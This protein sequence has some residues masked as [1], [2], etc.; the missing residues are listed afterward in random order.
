MLAEFREL[1]RYRDLLMVLVARDIKVRYKRSALGFFWSLINP[2]MQTLVLTIVFKHVLKI[3]QP[4]YS[5]WVLAAI[6]PWTF[7]QNSVLDAAQSILLHYTLVKKV[8]FPREIIPL[9]SVISNLIHLGLSFLVFL[10]YALVIGIHFGPMLLWLPLLVFFHFL[11]NVGVALT[12]AAMNVYYEDVKFI[13]QIVVNLLFYTCP[14][15]YTTA[16]IVAWDEGLTHGQNLASPESDRL[17]FLYRMN[18]VAS[19]IIAYQ[20]VLL[21]R[22]APLDPRPLDPGVLGITFLQC[23]LIAVFGYLFFNRRKWEFAERL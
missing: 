19:L 4:N 12:V 14:I 20:K 21:S 5:A 6:L 17:F 8:Y 15:I 1:Y 3:Q 18:P 11:L 22:A 23:L 10:V 16:H 2:L 13:V 9:S 7:F